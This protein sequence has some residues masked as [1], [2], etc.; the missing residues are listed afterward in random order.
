VARGK[1]NGQARRS[2]RRGKNRGNTDDPPAKGI[3]IHFKAS[4]GFNGPGF[5]G[6]VWRSGTGLLRRA[7]TDPTGRT[8][9]ALTHS[10]KGG[11]GARS[12]AS[13]AE[14]DHQLVWGGRPGARPSRRWRWPQIEQLRAGHPA[15]P[16]RSPRISWPGAAAFDQPAASEAP[17]RANDRSS[18]S[19]SA[20][21]GTANQEWPCQFKLAFASS[22]ESEAVSVPSGVAVKAAARATS[23]RLLRWP[24]GLTSPAG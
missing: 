13:P 8:V 11:A 10:R 9:V 12:V 4:P 3:H 22:L 16:G 6:S 2:D 14:L 23:P 1:N 19:P 20:G 17:L 7:R 5:F 18:A 21:P 24:S 15:A